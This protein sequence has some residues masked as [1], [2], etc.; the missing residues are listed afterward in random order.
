MLSTQ[1]PGRFVPAR[2][3]ALSVSSAIGPAESLVGM[4]LTE[5]GLGKY[6]DTEFVKTTSR[7]IQEA[8]DMTQEEMD[9]AA[10][11]LLHNK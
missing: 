5:Q 6:C 1:R 11:Q 2:P 7:E 9:R 10:H 3:I 8:L 4:V